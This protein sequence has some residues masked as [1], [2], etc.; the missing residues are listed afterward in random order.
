[1]PYRNVSPQRMFSQ[2]ALDHTPSHHFAE[3]PDRDF[4]EWKAETLPL[5]L[6]TL[7]DAPQ[8]VPANAELTAEWEEGGLL[9]QRWLMDVDRH[10]S[11][12]LLVNRPLD[13]PKNAK[14]PTL[15]CWSGHGNYGKESVMGNDSSPA[16]KAEIVQNNYDYGRQMAKKGYVTYSIDWMGMGEMND[17]GKPS[18][19]HSGEG[20]DPC[21]LYYLHA[22]MLGMTPLSIN[23]AHGRLA[24]DFVCGLPFVDPARLG[25][26]GL[27]GG[28]TMT[29]WTALTDPRF[30]AAEIACFSDLWAAFGF[31]DAFYCGMQIAPGLYK[32]VDLPDLHGLIAPNPLLVDIGAYDTCF[33]VETAMKSHKQVEAIYAA[34]GAAD[35]LELDFFAGEHAWG[36]N[37]SEAFFAKHLK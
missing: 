36:G 37:K 6:A 10:L 13:A 9:K 34:A 23:L 3:N 31:R 4:A 8:P 30:R 16:R 15:L 12:S 5:V 25:V 1:M 7:G 19:V 24:T 28:G 21:D 18:F 26:M 32:L 22:T 20:K 33:Y 35:R 17:R 11:T 27:S 14:L 29:L 2:W